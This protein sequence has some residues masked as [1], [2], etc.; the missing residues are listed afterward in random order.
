MR[1]ILMISTTWTMFT[2]RFSVH[3]YNNT[4]LYPVQQNE[5]DTKRVSTYAPACPWTM[6]EQASS[7]ISRQNSVVSDAPELPLTIDPQATKAKRLK[8]GLLVLKRQLDAH[9]QLNQR[10]EEHPAPEPSPSLPAT[11]QPIT[12]SA[13]NRS[14]IIPSRSREKKEMF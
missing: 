10:E 7:M 4:F 14:Y 6:A 13:L 2:S 3:Q 5:R 9:S 12:S 8:D 1:D 11:P